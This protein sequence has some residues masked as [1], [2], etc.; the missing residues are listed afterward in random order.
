MD[1]TIASNSLSLS[2]RH[3]PKTCAISE[4]VAALCAMVHVAYVFGP[5]WVTGK[6]WF[7]R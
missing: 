1:S 6:S 3:P 5:L 4:L 2:V 7:L